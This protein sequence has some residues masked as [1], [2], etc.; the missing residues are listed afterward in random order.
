MGGLGRLAW[1]APLANYAVADLRWTRYAALAAKFEAPYK[2]PVW[3]RAR[4]ARLRQR[5]RSQSRPPVSGVAGSTI[6][7]ARWHLQVTAVPQERPTPRNP[8]SRGDA[9]TNTIPMMPE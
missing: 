9:I 6:V 8:R 7:S 1:S 5:R 4:Q 2:R 3:E